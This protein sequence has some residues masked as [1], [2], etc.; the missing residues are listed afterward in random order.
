MWS[1]ITSSQ[2]GGQGFVDIRE[3]LVHLLV[4]YKKGKNLAKY[5]SDSLL[6][7]ISCPI[8]I[9]INLTKPKMVSQDTEFATQ[10]SPDPTYR[11][12]KKCFALFVSLRFG[13]IFVLRLKAE[14]KSK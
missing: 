4:F 7:C 11:K 14:A 12:E 6:V 8:E 1:E 5:I 3:R 13:E 2:G 9:Y 10:N